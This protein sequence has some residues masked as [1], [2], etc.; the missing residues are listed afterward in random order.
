MTSLLAALA[1][2]LGLLASP[3]GR[4]PQLD[5]PDGALKAFSENDKSVHFIDEGSVRREGGR[6]GLNTYTVFHQG[7]PSGG[8]VIVH[9]TTEFRV[10]CA[11]RTVQQL[12]LSAYDEAGGEVLWLPTEPDEHVE[13]G[14]LQDQVHQTVCETSQ[15][16][17]HPQVTGW[18]AALAFGRARLGS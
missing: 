8:R 7:W 18:R 6:V 1:L 9:W 4:P 16:I 2:S 14:T 12:R 15:A 5:L 17:P 3:Q 10:D 11:R 13:P